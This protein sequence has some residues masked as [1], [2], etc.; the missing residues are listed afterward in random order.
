MESEPN[1][2]AFKVMRRVAKSEGLAIE[3]ASAVAFA[4]LQKLVSKAFIKPD[5]LMVVSCTGQ[6]FPVENHVL[7]DK[8]TVYVLTQITGGC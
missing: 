2:D 1:G 8:R 7:D 5:D 4:C 6:T 3:P